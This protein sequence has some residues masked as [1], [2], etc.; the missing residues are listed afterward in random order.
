MGRPRS[1]VAA[2]P[3][4]HR[5]TELA[6]IHLLYWICL[7][8]VFEFTVSNVNLVD[9]TQSKVPYL[10]L[11]SPNILYLNGLRTSDMSYTFYIRKQQ[12][13]SYI[14]FNRWNL[15]FLDKSQEKWGLGEKTRHLCSSLVRFVAKPKTTF[16]KPIASWLK[17][18]FHWWLPAPY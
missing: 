18:S 1:S 17:T 5:L 13:Y 2:D 16:S 7:A 9:F 4:L 15:A 12:C 14:C 3:F 11:Q 8:I 6:H 10:E